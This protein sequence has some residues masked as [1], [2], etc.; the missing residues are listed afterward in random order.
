MILAADNTIFAR[1][2][3]IRLGDFNDI[4]TLVTD[5]TPDERFINQI[6][7]AEAQILVAEEEA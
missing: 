1:Q 6:E 5:K 7:S 4:D 2:A 3:M